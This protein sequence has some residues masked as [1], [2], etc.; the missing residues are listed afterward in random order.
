[1]RHHMNQFKTLSSRQHGHTCL[2]LASLRK[3]ELNYSGILTCSFLQQ[4][5]VQ[6]IAYS[7]GLLW[8]AQTQNVKKPAGPPL[9]CNFPINS[10]QIA[11]SLKTFF[12]RFFTKFFFKLV[13]PAR[14]CSASLC[15]PALRCVF[16]SSPLS[17]A[18]SV[19]VITA[20]QFSKH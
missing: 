17:Q 15:G 4:R 6:C 13:A 1:M 7:A 12:H 20:Y 8:A 16:Y 10:L 5:M 9:Q 3:T 11:E 19:Y 14:T 2:G 18:C